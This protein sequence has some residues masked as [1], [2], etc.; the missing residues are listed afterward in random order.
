MISCGKVY[1]NLP[2]GK[3]VSKTSPHAELG[4]HAE[5]ARPCAVANVLKTCTHSRGNV[6][7]SHEKVDSQMVKLRT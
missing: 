3:G 2:D 4:A 5:A 7:D 6:V 1:R